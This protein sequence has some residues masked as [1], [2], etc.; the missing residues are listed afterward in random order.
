[1]L[2]D[3][4][5]TLGAWVFKSEILSCPSSIFRPSFLNLYMGIFDDSVKI[6]K[7]KM[8]KIAKKL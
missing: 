7:T 8:R 5:D 4:R 1:M 3:W 2:L 6:V